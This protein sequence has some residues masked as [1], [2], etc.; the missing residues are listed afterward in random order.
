MKTFVTQLI[1]F[2]VAVLIGE[3]VGRYLNDWIMNVS[4]RSSCAT[5]TLV[6]SNT[7][8][9]PPVSI[10]QCVSIAL[11]ICQPYS[12]KRGSPVRR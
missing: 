8:A 11:K 6:T 12:R 4:I 2:Q 3:T 10:L 1:F 5:G 9:Y 7:L